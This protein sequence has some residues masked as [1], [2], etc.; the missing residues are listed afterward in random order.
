MA[1]LN[2]PVNAN[3]LVDRFNDFVAATANRNIVWGT[4]NKP[5]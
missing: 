4:G 5:F 2:N 1:T 3:N